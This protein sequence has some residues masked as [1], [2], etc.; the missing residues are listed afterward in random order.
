MTEILPIAEAR[1]AFRGELFDAGLLVPTGVD[2][3]YGR[4]GVF[5]DVVDAIDREVVAA[6]AGEHATRLRFP[7]IMPREVF[8]R[9]D[10]L[11]SF[12]NLAGSVHTFG[13]GDAE[14]AA[15]L[16][17]H[18]RGEDWTTSLE[19]AGVMLQPA[20]CHPLYPLNTG[21]LPVDGRRYDVYGY[22]FRHE[23]AIDPARLQSFRMHEYVYLGD[24]D[25]AFAHR[26]TWI[27]RGMTVLEALGLEAEPVVANDPFFGRVGR[28][29]ANNQREEVLKIELV[30]SLYGDENV[31]AIV[32]SNLHRDHFGVNFG[33]ETADGAVAHS[34][35]VGFG[36]ERIALAMFRKHGLDPAQWAPS[37]RGRLWP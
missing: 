9:T 29:L 33:I 36:M 31:T 18:E 12:P 8:E 1:A 20:A 25:A 32:S 16:A 13:G 2:G 35:C 30:V 26:E 28:I 17:K 27:A 4:S 10:Y 37:L 5:E 21:R 34:A 11:A 7:P 22:C 23:P 19:P 24:P 14:H 15:L 3:L 6:G